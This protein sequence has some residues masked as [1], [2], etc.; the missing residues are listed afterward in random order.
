MLDKQ[1]RIAVW[2]EGGKS[3][4]YALWSVEL[5]AIGRKFVGQETFEK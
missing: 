3:V 5:I 1:V 2:S 4:N